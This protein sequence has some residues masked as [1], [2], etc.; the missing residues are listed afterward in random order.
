MTAAESRENADD[1]TRLRR[2]LECLVGI[3][4]TEGN[5]IQVLHNGD[6]IFP[7]MLEA[8]RGAE[9][10]VDLMTFVYWKGEPARQFADAL[11]ERARAGVRVRVLIDAVSGFQIEQG[12]VDAMEAD[13][14]A[15]QFFRKPW[16]KSPFKQN[17]RCHRKVCVVDETLGFTGGVGIAEEWAGDA[18]DSSEWRDT[19]FRVE[20]PAVDGLIAAF[21]SNW[22]EDG[23]ALYDGRDQFPE[24][25]EAGDAV[26]QVVR[27]TATLAWDDIE[28]VW[29]VLFQS[30]RH[31]IRLQTA[32]FSPDDRLMSDL[33]DAAARGVEVDVLIPG[34]HIDKRVSLVASES[35]YDEL[36][37]AGI[38]VWR[39]QPTMLHTKVLL[40]DDA[41]ALIGSSNLNRRSLDHDEEVALVIIDEPTSRVLEE[42]FAED[43]S[44]SEQIDLTR[45]RN[46]SLPQR[47]LEAAV[48]PVRRWL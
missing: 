29:H 44:R 47:V 10:T 21:V 48:E 35:L 32:Y 5:A 31:R 33:K 41:A 14:V 23:R 39:Y 19:H 15:V 1:R 12:L 18:R 3:H 37:R 6:E 2:T 25:R 4:F 20:G 16:V 36:V 34:E 38:R 26:V 27:G 24:Q 28:T 43:L 45:W 40:V 22:A 8:I 17:H 11:A 7:A 42:H 46:R 30:A 13:G 9:R